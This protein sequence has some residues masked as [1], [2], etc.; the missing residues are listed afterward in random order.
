MGNCTGICGS[1][2]TDS[3]NVLA[4]EETQ[5]DKGISAETEKKRTEYVQ[6]N[7]KKQS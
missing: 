6:N 2:E 3:T 1:K 7:S 5:L 4:K